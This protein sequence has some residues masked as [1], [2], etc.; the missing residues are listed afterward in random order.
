VRRTD[1]PEV[2]KALVKVSEQSEE[3]IRGHTE[4]VYKDTLSIPD[5]YISTMDETWRLFPDVLVS[6]EPL[7]FGDVVD[8]RFMEF[9]NS[10]DI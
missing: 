1:N 9:A 5:D 6:E 3:A 4:F 10:L 2:F 7:T 8:T